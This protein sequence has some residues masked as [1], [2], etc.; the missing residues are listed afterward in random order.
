VRLKIAKENLYLRDK[1][2]EERQV[3]NSKMKTLET[4]IGQ[5]KLAVGLL[6]GNETVKGKSPFFHTAVA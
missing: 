4:E 3:H 6:K 2:Q 5:L 1:M